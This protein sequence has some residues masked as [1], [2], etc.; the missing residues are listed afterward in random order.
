VRAPLSDVL[1]VSTADE[2]G[3]LLAQL[4]E[5]LLEL[6]HLVSQQVHLRRGR[7]ACARGRA[8]ELHDALLVLDSHVVHLALQFGSLLLGVALE[9]LE[10]IAVRL[11]QALALGLELRLCARAP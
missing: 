6:L 8:R 5:L 10:L 7:A 11:Q 4:E 9:A 1:S 3:V 2:F